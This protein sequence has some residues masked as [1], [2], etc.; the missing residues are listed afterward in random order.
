[1]EIHYDDPE[2]ILGN[3]YKGIVR[4][5][6][7]GINAAFV[8]VGLEEKLFLSMKELSDEL[9]Q[10]ARGQSPQIQKLL[11]SGQQ[12]ILQV[13]REGIGTKNPQGTMKISLPG[14]YWVFLP[15]HE[16]LGVSRRIEDEHESRR[17]RRIARKLKHKGEGLIARTAAQ[18]ASEEDLERDF[19]YLLGTWK[20]I[21][22]QAARV[23]APAL[24]YRGLDFSQGLLARPADRGRQE[25]GSRQR[26][27]LSRDQRFSVL[28]A[29]GSVYGSHRALSGEAAAL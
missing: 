25:G 19:N 6:L 26:T 2:R 1:M 14:R 5:I 20:G 10:K 24:L 11:K 7:P 8:D 17:L 4:D 23:K 15:T 9:W 18:G 21:E 16:R 13:K 22:E 3:I 28:Y 12:I 29:H 27:G